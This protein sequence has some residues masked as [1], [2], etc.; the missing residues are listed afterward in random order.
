MRKVKCTGC[1]GVKRSLGTRFCSKS[2]EHSV[3][4]R[5][6]REL[7]KLYKQLRRKYYKK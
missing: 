4:L 5:Y 7:K 6:K 2:C 1:G 3:R